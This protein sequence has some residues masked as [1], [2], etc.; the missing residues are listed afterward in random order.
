MF[1]FIYISKTVKIYYNIPFQA[2]NLNSAFIRCIYILGHNMNVVHCH[3]CYS[4]TPTRTRIV[5]SRLKLN[6]KSI[7]LI[8][9]AIIALRM[10]FS[11]TLYIGTQSMSQFNVFR[12]LVWACKQIDEIIIIA[13]KLQNKHAKYTKYL[14]WILYSIYIK[15][16]HQSNENQSLIT[17][18]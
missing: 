12:L 9:I 8:V 1:I 7:I 13:G 2:R 6:S 18:T 14:P 4:I 3:G 15:L 17:N 10:I 5:Y 11:C 16:K